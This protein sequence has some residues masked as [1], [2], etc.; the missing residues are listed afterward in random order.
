MLLID[1]SFYLLLNRAG[2]ETLPTPFLGCTC[3][4]ESFQN[5]PKKKHQRETEEREGEEGHP[6]PVFP[7]SWPNCSSTASLGVPQDQTPVKCQVWS[8]YK[9]IYLRRSRMSSKICSAASERRRGRIL[10]QWARTRPESQVPP[11]LWRMKHS[12][13]IQGEKATS[14]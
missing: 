10:S 6:P 7:C 3:Q 8:E 11:W 9:G 13:T 1:P 2:A 5:L 14:C 12:E 4:R